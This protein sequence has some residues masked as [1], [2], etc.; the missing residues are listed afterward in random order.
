MADGAVGPGL[1]AGRDWELA[2]LRQRRGEAL[3]G[4]GRLVVLTGP[5][6]IGKTRLT[7]ELADGARR[8]RSG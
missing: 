8:D 2:A 4:H 3:T 7:E 6:G 1:L 5:P